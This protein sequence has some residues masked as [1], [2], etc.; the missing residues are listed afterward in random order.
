MSAVHIAIRRDKRLPSSYYSHTHTHT[1]PH[2]DKPEGKLSPIKTAVQFYARAVY[3]YLFI[4]L[5]YFI[6]SFC[7][8][9]NFDQTQWPINLLKIIATCGERHWLAGNTV[10]ATTTTAKRELYSFLSLCRCVTS[11]RSLLEFILQARTDN[12]LY[13]LIEKILRKNQVVYYM[14]IWSLWWN[15]TGFLSSCSCQYYCMDEPPEL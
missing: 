9:Y 8:F 1:H 3:F 13:L 11:M 14:E 4:Y 6:Y 12:P 7:D 5:F 2:S 10:L 15:K